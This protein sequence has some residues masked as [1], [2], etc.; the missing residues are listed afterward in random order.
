MHQRPLLFLWLFTCFTF[1][2]L[3]GSADSQELD[4]DPSLLTIRRLFITKE[5]ESEPVPQLRWSKKSSTYFTLDKAQ[6]GSGVDLVRHD[7][8]TG[9]KEVIVPAERFIPKGAKEPLRV[10]GLEFSADE[11][12][13]LIF[14]KS[15]KVW[16]RNTRGDY[17]LLDISEGELK[18]LGGQAAPSSLMFG[19]FSLT[20]ANITSTFRTYNLW[21]SLL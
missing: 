21:K 13:L 7:P 20:L 6:K 2:M 15:Q 4:S 18:K 17:W 12:R 8:A 9:K 14:T 16:R 11:S 19:K 5:F 10:E 3:S 1:S